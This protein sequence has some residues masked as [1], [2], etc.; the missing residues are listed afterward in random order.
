LAL[1]SL[2]IAAGGIG[3]FVSFVLLSAGSSSDAAAGTS[4]FAAFA[5]V[6]GISGSV[7]SSVLIGAGLLSMTMLATRPRPSASKDDSY[8]EADGLHAG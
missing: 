5:I 2:A 7:A 3:M 6:A 1:A 8:S 4:G